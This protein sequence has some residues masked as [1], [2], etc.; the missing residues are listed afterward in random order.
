MRNQ[1]QEVPSRARVFR[2]ALLARL[3]NVD[4]KSVKW[5]NG[6]ESC[7]PWWTVRMRCGLKKT[8]P[9][10]SYD[11]GDDLGYKRGRNE[12]EAVSGKRVA[13]C[14]SSF[15]RLE[16]VFLS[17]FIKTR[18]KTRRDGRLWIPWKLNMRPVP[19]GNSYTNRVEA[20]CR[21]FSI[22]W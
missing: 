13:P 9:L 6:E 3:Y 12:R 15:H 5:R 20:S 18:E 1:L 22:C 2:N 7:P 10:A 17:E 8:K 11:D 21:S 19:L 16:P 14:A 4:R